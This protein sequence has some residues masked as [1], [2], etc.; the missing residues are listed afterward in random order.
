[1]KIS[2][3]NFLVVLI[4]LKFN[5]GFSYPN[6]ASVISI[7][8][9]QQKTYTEQKNVIHP[10]LLSAFCN[11]E[12]EDYYIKLYFKEFKA[13]N[14]IQH[15]LE[16]LYNSSHRAS[17]DSDSTNFF[18]FL[19]R[20][21][22]KVKLHFQIKDNNL[23]FVVNQYYYLHH[24]KGFVKS[25]DYL[26]NEVEVDINDLTPNLASFFYLINLSSCSENAND[27][28]NS[29]LYLMRALVLSEK[30]PP[31]ENIT[32]KGN[33]YRYL[34]ARFYN[35]KDYENAQ[36]YVEKCINTFLPEFEN[37][38]GL[39]VAYEYKGLSIFQLTKNTEEALLYF[40]KAQNIHQIQNNITR[41]NYVEKLKAEIFLETDPSLATEYIFNFID[42]F[43]ENNRQ[44]HLTEGWLIAHGIIQFHGLDYLKITQNRYI[45]H[46]E[47]IQKLTKYLPEE[48][49]K[50]QLKISNAFIEYYTNNNN[51]D[52]LEKYNQL[53]NEYEYK[54]GLITE[55]QT[56]ENVQ[57]YL[58]NFDKEQKLADLNLLHQKRTYQNKLLAGLVCILLLFFFSIA[59]YKRKQK[60]AMMAKYQLKETENL[61]LS[62]E[63]KLKEEL[64]LRKIQDEKILKLAL[65]NEAQKK[66]LLELELKQKQLEIEAVKLESHANENLLNEVF[67]TLKDDAVNDASQLLKKLK[68]YKLIKQQTDSLKEILESVSPIFMNQIEKTCPNLTDQDILY[69]TLIRQK[70]S[71]Q[72]IADFL[73]VSAKS[74]NQHKYRLK[75][76]LNIPKEVGIQEFILNLEQ[77]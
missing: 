39:G 23:T 66:Q 13:E 48:E 60:Q 70:Y 29:I 36:Y 45:T 10:Y 50:N 26:M 35:L 18:N 57:L 37:S 40:E 25:C 14:E 76:K 2:T 77:L 22:L 63:Q 64:I 34:S 33:V 28:N 46:Q 21:L 3:L 65:H 4:L 15:M 58:N 24:R 54:R 43:H 44:A 59:T 27:Y 11:S 62:A 5:I 16:Q 42:Y 72:Q 49:L 74:V 31:P 68:T 9:Y 17:L 52:S 12:M 69:C 75:K 8:E 51:K 41:Y 56:Q 7:E 32:R 20:V 61:K 38:I 71:T 19:N 30:L 1:M 73:S 55:K 47:V 53:Q 67:I 6:C